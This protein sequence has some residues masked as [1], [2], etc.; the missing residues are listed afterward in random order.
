MT[1]L[2]KRKFLILMAQ[3]IKKLEAR[4]VTSPTS[5][6]AKISLGD[7]VFLQAGCDKNNKVERLEF[8][9]TRHPVRY[10]C[11][12]EMIEAVDLETLVPGASRAEALQAYWQMATQNWLEL[13][14]DPTLDRQDCARAGKLC[15]GNNPKAMEAGLRAMGSDHPHTH[16]PLCWLP[17][18]N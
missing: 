15:K 6:V 12:S 1:L 18:R 8:K 16:Q 7:T 10:T 17:S 4:L 9:V 11:A 13:D 3:L 5:Y 14:T 2:L